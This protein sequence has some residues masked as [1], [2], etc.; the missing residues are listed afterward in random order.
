MVKLSLPAVRQ[1][2]YLAG[3]T[4]SDEKEFSSKIQ[5]SATRYD[6]TNKG[7]LTVREWFN[8]I[9]VQNKVDISLDRLQSICEHLPRTKKDKIKISDFMSLPI[10]SEEAFKAIDRNKDGYISLG[11]LKLANK[12]KPI[13]D[14]AEK[15]EDLDMDYDR[16][17]DIRE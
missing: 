8:V 13:R 10:L 6:H 15:I 3:G 5:R 12:E 17:L 9:K 4:T 1:E 7:E 14:I 11:E 2:L 16:K